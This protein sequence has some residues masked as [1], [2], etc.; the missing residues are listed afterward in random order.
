ML[1]FFWSRSDSSSGTARIEKFTEPG[2]FQLKHTQLNEPVFSGST[3]SFHRI[4]LNLLRSR[5]TLA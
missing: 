3:L 2:R 1:T 4:T 5:K